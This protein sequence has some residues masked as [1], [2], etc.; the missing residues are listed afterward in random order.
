MKGK[1]LT[2]F[3]NSE[4]KSAKESLEKHKTLS[5][6]SDELQS[7][8]SRYS[9]PSELDTGGMKVISRVYDKITDRTLVKAC[10]KFPDDKNHVELFLR[11][12]RITACLQHPNIVPI[13]DIGFETD[14]SPYFIM[15]M[16]E[17]NNYRDYLKNEKDL[18][19]KLSTFLKVC[20]GI[21]YAH[22]QGIVHLDLK[23][24]NI[25]VGEHG[26]VIIIDWGLA[27]VIYE[28]CKE[29]LLK[30]DSLD[31]CNLQLTLFGRGTPGYMAPEQFK[32]GSALTRHSDIYSLGAI[33]YFLL[34]GQPPHQGKNY[35]EIKSKTTTGSIKPPSLLA[36]DREIPLGLEAICMKALQL[37]PADRYQNV[38]DMTA[39]IRSYMNGFAPKAENAGFLT[40]LKLLYL[41][42]KAIINVALT[43]LIIIIAGLSWFIGKIKESENE[44][45]LARERLENEAKLRESAE[46]TALRGTVSIAWKNLQEANLKGAMEQTSIAMHYAPNYVESY[47]LATLINL[48]KLNFN[49]ALHYSQKISSGKYPVLESICQRL[50]NEKITPRLYI[51][52]VKVFE[53]S[54]TE[55]IYPYL[56]AK[57]MLELNE[58][59]KNLFLKELIQL[60]NKKLDMSSVSLS[61]DL[62]NIKI[63][64]EN[65]TDLPPMPDTDFNNADFSGSALENIAELRYLKVQNLNL[66]GTKVKRLELVDDTHSNLQSLNISNSEITEISGRV[67]QIHKLNISGCQL[68]DFS[69]ILKFS[70]LQEITISKNQLPDSTLKALTCKVV[71][72]LP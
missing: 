4:Y 35:E 22:S 68:K 59:D 19:A 17:G 3:L 46:M 64:S 32:N 52:L 53:V 37:K 21:D 6:I 13:H 16:I 40:Q 31:F 66:S 29:E 1:N 42:N 25:I 23:P 54:S 28:D 27:K 33:L 20:D 30:K 67:E 56:I 44:N 55:K 10:S 60:H 36:P 72:K 2:N 50:A 11:E 18:S 12:A 43:A 7:C 8:E 57:I 47:R 58:E 51:E 71:E 15:K 48:A 24:A 39:E 9:D 34:T 70:G 45:R 62:K 5:M 65:F 61:N 41:R 69:S 63:S 49:D 38:E 14:G 26:E